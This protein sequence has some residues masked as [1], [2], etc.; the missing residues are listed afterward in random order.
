M[1]DS[2]EVYEIYSEAELR[3]KVTNLFEDKGWETKTLQYAG[4]LSKE[5]SSKERLDLIPDIA[6]LN[7]EN[8]LIGIVKVKMYENDNNERLFYCFR[9]LQQEAEQLIKGLDAQ[10]VMFFISKKAVIYAKGNEKDSYKILHVDNIPAPEDINNFISEAKDARTI[11]RKG[12]FASFL[13]SESADQKKKGR[14]T[15]ICKY[16]RRTTI[17]I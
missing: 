12:K 13:K 11:T 14:R 5:N 10:F 9:R 8:K 6:L 17:C 1:C 4:E 2:P 3:K 7:N 16:G 15:T